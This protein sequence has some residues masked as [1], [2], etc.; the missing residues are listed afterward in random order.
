MIGPPTR[1]SPDMKLA[2]ADATAAPTDATSAPPL[3]TGDTEAAA[4]D[5]SDED[6]AGFR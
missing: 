1:K 3:S 5:G 2:P 4:T 6:A